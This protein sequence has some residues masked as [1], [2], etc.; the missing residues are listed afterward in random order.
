MIR[1]GADAPPWSARPRI[2]PTPSFR[3]SS[4]PRTAGTS[5]AY[6]VLPFRSRTWCIEKSPSVIPPLRSGIPPTT[7]CAGGLLVPVRPEG[8]SCRP[9][10]AAPRTGCRI[11]HPPG[12]DPLRRRSPAFGPSAPEFCEWHRCTG[13]PRCLLPACS[14]CFHASLHGNAHHAPRTKER[15]VQESSPSP[16]IGVSLRF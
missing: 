12:V 9:H 16:F 7:L 10:P 14:A 3:R 11:R 1:K 8:G 6:S 2:L 13:G 4:F 5:E 15:A